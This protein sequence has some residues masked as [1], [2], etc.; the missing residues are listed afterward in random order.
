MPIDPDYFTIAVLPDTQRYFVQEQAGIFRQQVEWILSQ[1]EHFNI[2][3]VLHE[4][5]VVEHNTGEEWQQAKE[6]MS[7][8]DGKIPYTF[9]LGNHDMGHHGNSDTRE[10]GFHEYFPLSSFEQASWWGGSFNGYATNSYALLHAVQ[11]KWL[12]LNLDFGVDEP[13]VQWAGDIINCYPDHRVII[14]THCYLFSDG[15]LVQEGHPFNPKSYP[16]GGLDGK[17]LWEEFV[18]KHATIN[19]VLC[20]HI[21]YGSAYLASK[22]NQGNTVHQLLAN[23]QMLENGGNGWFRLLSFRKDLQQV[24]VDTFS[25]YLNR[26]H[27][28]PKEHFTFSM[29]I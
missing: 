28:D 27:R 5:D 18:S 2:R 9:S 3:F 6:I 4:G 13:V 22:G 24:R 7:L 29:E 21:P 11:R 12:I 17:A 8:F 14:N 10:T 15:K 1:R 26:Y 25:P 20:G 16:I 23:Y 19:L